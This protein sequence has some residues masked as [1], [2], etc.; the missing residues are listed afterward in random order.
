MSKIYLLHVLSFVTFFPWYCGTLLHS[1]GTL[2][3][4]WLIFFSCSICLNT[5]VMSWVIKLSHCGLR[6]VL[7][8][9]G[10]LCGKEPDTWI[11]EGR[12]KRQANVCPV[13]RL[14]CS[15]PHL[16]TRAH[17]ASMQMFFCVPVY[18]WSLRCSTKCCVL[19]WCDQ[20]LNKYL[21]KNIFYTLLH[22][23]VNFKT[24]PDCLMSNL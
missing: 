19:I 12:V 7:G 21:L 17:L 14:I 9:T 22:T 13:Q 2:C 24:L 8:S 10:T 20:M 6:D 3:S 11:S 15:S 4:N 1:L 23:F 16:I 5:W 18:H